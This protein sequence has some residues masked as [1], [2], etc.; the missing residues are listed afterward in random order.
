M[1]S[2]D[3]NLVDTSDQELVEGH[4]SPNYWAEM[5]KDLI[6]REY[7]HLRNVEEICS[8]LGISAGHFRE[9]FRLEYGITPKAYLTKVKIEEAKKLLEGQSENI[10]DIALKVGIPSTRVFRSC[11]KEL[12]GTSPSEYRRTSLGLEI[13]SRK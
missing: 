6:D 1:K 12:V 3:E 5:G 11:F 13:D 7:S 2:L 10:C 4:L 8:V 9:K